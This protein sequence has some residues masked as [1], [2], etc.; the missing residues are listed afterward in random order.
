MTLKEEREEEEKKA[1]VEAK[2]LIR[3]REKPKLMG[4]STPQ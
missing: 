4:P 2:R 3:V 1:R